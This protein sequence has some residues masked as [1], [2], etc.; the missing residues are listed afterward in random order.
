M[1]KD[2]DDLYHSCDIDGHEGIQFTEF[3]VLLCLTYLLGKPATTTNNVSTAWL[4]LM[5]FMFNA[6][7][8]YGK[9]LVFEVHVGF[10]L[11]L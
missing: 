10:Q 1:D 4:K 11:L 3:V 2:I 9:S 8:Y 6:P 7:I 5:H